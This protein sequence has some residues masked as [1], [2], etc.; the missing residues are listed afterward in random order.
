[1]QLAHEWRE[2]GNEKMRASKPREAVAAYR[3]APAYDAADDELRYR[4][5]LALTSAGALDEA[6]AYLLSMLDREPGNGRYNLSLARIESARHDTERA[7]EYYKAALL[8][9]WSKDEIGGRTEA[10]QELIH[11][12]MVSGD[13]QQ[14]VAQTLAL[15]ADQPKD[16]AVQLEAAETLFRQHRNAEAG[17]IVSGYLRMKADDVNAVSYKHLTLPTIY[18]V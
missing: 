5:A 10:W 11:L 1:V 12:L 7:V 15:S 16:S 14:A 9:Q 8:S 2:D 4:L 6:A 18:V 3:N 13:V 17:E